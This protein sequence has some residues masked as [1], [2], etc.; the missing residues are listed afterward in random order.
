M[1]TAEL[2]GVTVRIDTGRWSET[3][4]RGMD[5][6]VAPGRIL[7][8]LGESGCGKSIAA[9]ALTG[10]LP[11][12]ARLTG[13][14]PV[15]GVP[16]RDRRDR[17]RLR[18]GTIGLV[19]QEGVTA[20]DPSRTVGAQLRDLER[21]HGHWS[22]ARACEA[23]HYP[24]ELLGLYPKEHS[25]GQIQRAA[26]AAALLP[27]PGVL[28]AD[29]PAASLD[30]ATAYGVWTTLRRYAD[31]GAAVLVITHDVHMLTATRVADRLALMRDGRIAVTGDLDELTSMT[32]PYVHA[33]LHQRTYY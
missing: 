6:T 28:V 30:T 19:P 20:F 8:L 10:T 4:L 13:E 26:L 21:L 1:T 5:L 27:G 25:G 22:V 31:S 3:V 33:F 15:G 18:N 12:P 11:E 29:E 14:V 24:A 23:A 2:R 16:V 7:A 17:L 32:D 9:A